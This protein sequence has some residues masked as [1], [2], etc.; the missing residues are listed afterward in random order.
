[1]FDDNP[2]ALD[3]IV[4]LFIVLVAA[5]IL[6]S[7]IALAVATWLLSRWARRRHRRGSRLA[8]FI[9]ALGSEVFIIAVLNVQKNT[10]RVDATIVKWLVGS[11]IAIGAASI[12]LCQRRPAVEIPGG[13]A[14]DPNVDETT[15]NDPGSELRD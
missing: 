6:A 8:A 5:F 1:M 9:I 7:A 2:E 4:Q 15:T 3:D 10:Y 14:F 12:R 11:A 13:A